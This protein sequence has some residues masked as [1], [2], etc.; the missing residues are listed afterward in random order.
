MLLQDY[1]HAVAE[2]GGVGKDGHQVFT[3]GGFDFGVVMSVVIYTLAGN[4]MVS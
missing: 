3:D 2:M 1:V 4:S